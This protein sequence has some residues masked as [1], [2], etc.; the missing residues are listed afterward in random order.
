MQSVVVECSPVWTV[1]ADSVGGARMLGKAKKRRSGRCGRRKCKD[2]GR[3]GSRSST[4]DNRLACVK[5]R[6]VHIVDQEPV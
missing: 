6:H 5:L 3:L 4:M 1:V 2:R